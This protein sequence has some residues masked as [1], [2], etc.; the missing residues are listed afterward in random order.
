MEWASIR[1]LKMLLGEL[2][3][4]ILLRPC[5]NI[6]MK[7][8]EQLNSQYFKKHKEKAITFLMNGRE[9]IYRKNTKSSSTP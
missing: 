5:L 8:E 6:L 7:E 2:S 4:Q 3:I 1:D 9:K